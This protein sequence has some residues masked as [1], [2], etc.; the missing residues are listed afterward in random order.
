MSPRADDE[1]PRRGTPP[2]RGASR[3]VP[4]EG[5]DEQP[6]RADRRGFSSIGEA[7]AYTPRGRTVAER[8]RTPRTGRTADPFRPALQVVEGGEGGPRT[9]QRAARPA[10]EPAGGRNSREPAPGTERRSPRERAGNAEPRERAGNAEPRQRAGNAEPRERAGSDEPRGR[11]GNGEPRER[12]DNRAPRERAGK[13]DPREAARERAAKRD[14]R[15][16]GRERGEKRDPREMA[17]ER[18]ER[19][20][21]R[22]AR[23]AA[24]A[25]RD[26]RDGARAPRARQA[27]A[28]EPR[29]RRTADPEAGARRRV[30]GGSGPGRE[31][32]RRLRPV[33]AEPPK[34]ANST[35]RLRLGTILALSLFTMIGIR[36]VVLQVATSPAE[37]DKLVD[38][39]N[40]RMH[41]IKLPA[42]RGSILDRDGNILANSVEA[43]YIFADPSNPRLQNDIPGTA[44]ALA[45]LL[46]VPASKLAASM[47][48]K[49]VDGKASQ[50]SYLARGVDVSV[51]NQIEAL[52]KP[53]IYTHADERRELPGKDLAAN[54]I[55]FIGDDQHGLEGLEARYDDLLHGT[56]GMWVF[57]SGKGKLDGPI[58]GGY[59]QET[60]A[61]PGGSLQ[62]TI[63]SF[64]QWNAQH[65]LDAE[66]ERNHATVAGAVVLDVKTGEILAQASY[67]YYNAA[68]ALEYQPS[69]RIDVP[70]A[71]VTD[72]G[73]THK[74]FVIGAALQEGL[75]TPDS[76]VEV[77]P[78]IVEG[79]K[80]FNDSHVQPKGSRLTIAGILAYSSN[81]GTIQIGSRLGK[82][83]IYEYQQKFGLGKATGEGMPGEAPGELLAP[84]NWS[85]SAKG[86]VPIGHSV[87]ATLV[88]M[89]AGYGA[90]AN[91]GVYIQP[92]LIKATVSGTDH[93]TTPAPAPETHR[94]LDAKIAAEL[95]TLMETVVEDSEGTGVKAQVPGYRVA[96]KTGTG[97]MVVDGEY[98]SHNASSFVG[99][100]PAENPR[101]VVAVAMDVAKGTG[102]EVAAPAFAQIMSDTLLRNSVPPSTTKPPTFKIHG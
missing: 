9:R 88:Q 91:D 5:T 83:K 42:A 62:L 93:T 11:V 51:A 31:P 95:R 16:T 55:G 84:Q 2:R 52:K 23:E 69:D 41:S 43:R 1:T 98:T 36:L 61:K 82:D 87:S 30:T 45:R 44:A 4:A 72:P 64:T 101:Y 99:M 63:N 27:S 18:A 39:R 85:G 12:A 25:R 34:L 19:R 80:T 70:T 50:F 96:G 92:H 75:I 32:A 68:K 7:R 81:V 17:R 67:P 38:L 89:A 66:A 47:Q 13:R 86:S 8:G 94:V 24:P 57:E 40:D 97:K 49:M 59:Q 33:P 71:V 54:L 73:S 102:G 77:A 76:T 56:D 90:I 29:S 79:G 20:D 46:G 53:G 22:P 15:E 14:P 65:I 21:P 37:V 48:P 100:A 26:G 74:A 28:D 78:A 10:G 58:A 35:R 6:E 3:A 60:P